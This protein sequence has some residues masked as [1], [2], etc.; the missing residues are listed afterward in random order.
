M[1]IRQKMFLLALMETATNE[2]PFGNQVEAY[3]K[4]YGV[5]PKDTPVSLSKKASQIIKRLIKNDEAIDFLVN[6]DFGIE[7]QGWFEVFEKLR[8][9]K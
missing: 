2:Y 4:S 5:K 6:R 9:E 1:T 3:K 7:R 8:K